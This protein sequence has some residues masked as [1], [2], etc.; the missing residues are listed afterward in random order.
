MLKWKIREQKKGWGKLVL[1]KI[2]LKKRKFSF[3]QLNSLLRRYFFSE[4]IVM[5]FFKRKSPNQSSF[6]RCHWKCCQFSHAFRTTAQDFPVKVTCFHTRPSPQTEVYL[7]VRLLLY[8]LILR[9]LTLESSLELTR[10]TFPKNSN[11]PRSSSVI[12]LT[13]LKSISCCGPCYSYLTKWG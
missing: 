9:F 13:G 12:M 2:T 6:R 3:F 4:S 5:G 1:Y 11:S 10:L 8:S 7:R